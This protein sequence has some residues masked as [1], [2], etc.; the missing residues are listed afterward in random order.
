MRIVIRAN[1]IL[2]QRVG[3]GVYTLNLIKNLARLDSNNEY[4]ICGNSFA[5]RIDAG[6]TSFFSQHQNFTFRYRRIPGKIMKTFGVKIPILSLD[7]LFGSCDIYHE[8]NYIPL[9]HKGKIV[10]TIY[11]MTYKTCPQ[12]LSKKTLPYLDNNL[13]RAVSKADK[14]IAISNSTKEDLIKYFDVPTNKISVVYGGYDKIYHPIYDHNELERIRSHYQ[15]PQK[16][17]LS[18]GTV[19]PRKNLSL[20]LKAYSRLPAGFKKEI[21]LVLVGKKGW[22][23]QTFFEEIK[24]LG[25]AGDITFT[26]FVP[27]EE[28]PYIYNLADL[29][30]Y[31]SFYEGFGLPVLE[32]M[33]CGTPVIVSNRSSLPEVVGDAGRL[34]DPE[35]YY[36]L[37][38][39]I[40]QIYRDQ[41]S[42][43]QMKN[44]GIEQAKKFS[45][46][47]CARETLL[48][49]Q[50]V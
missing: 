25:I 9:R 48:A 22:I 2:G 39:A 27:T 44:K 8:T 10:L 3:I 41:S 7:S 21:K 26:G 40:Q 49:Y 19:E 34:I 47:K 15:L 24:E 5:K 23:N 29:F 16:F 11:D 20:L 31:P 17:I 43:E 32:A 33:A 18:V 12:T 50:Q 45:W 42:R 36:E 13:Y 37:Q 35:D 46:E 1:M 4:L 28:L 14:L 30:V 38:T 6:V